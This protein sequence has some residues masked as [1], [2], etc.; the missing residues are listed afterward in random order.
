[1][2]VKE[3]ENSLYFQCLLNHSFWVI[4]KSRHN[5]SSKNIAKS[6]FWEFSFQTCQDFLYSCLIIPAFL[7]NMK[8]RHKEFSIC[9]AMRGCFMKCTFK[10]S[11]EWQSYS[12]YLKIWKV[13]NVWEGRN[14]N[15]EGGIKTLCLQ[16]SSFHS[17]LQTQVTVINWLFPTL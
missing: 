9:G 14:R 10:K 16:V 4:S 17:S 11:T 2:G 7:Q 15:R 8:W 1:M 3:R 5:L 13:R 6:L 12:Q